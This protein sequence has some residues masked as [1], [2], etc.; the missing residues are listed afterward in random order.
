LTN[1]ARAVRSP[2]VHNETAVWIDGE[3]QDAPVIS[4]LD[5]GFLV[6]DGVFETIKTVDGQPFALTRH[7]RRLERSADGLGLP[8]PPEPTIRSAVADVLAASAAPTGRLRITVTSGAGPLGSARGED[9]PTLVV[10]HTATTPWPP[11]TRLAT[12]SWARNERGATTGLKTTSY[13]DNVVALRAAREQGADEAIFTDTRGRICEGTGTNIFYVLNGHLTTPSLATGCLAGITRE[14]VIEV[15]DVMV[16][17]A[18][19]GMLA[20]VDE[21]F[22]TSST[23]DVQPVSHIDGRTLA[24]WPGPHT[25][26]AMAAFAALGARTF[27]P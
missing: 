25:A 3:V 17:D 15:A 13:A 12:V 20:D 4:P 16:A 18:P 11:S 27:D 26:E 8:L 7:L 21:A 22:V 9:P 23:R 14:L 2:A 1:T 5:H 19:V 10:T 24:G 6:G